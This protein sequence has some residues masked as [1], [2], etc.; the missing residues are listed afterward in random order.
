MALTSVISSKELARVAARAYEGKTV[1]VFLAISTASQSEDSLIS[2]W[3]DDELPASFGYSEYSQ[4]IGVG[5]YDGVTLQYDIA[6][7]FASFTATG[8]SLAWTEIVIYIDDPVLQS[9]TVT[10]T[11][12][13]DGTLHTITKAAGD[14][15]ADGFVAGEY[16]TVSGTSNVNGTYEISSVAALTLTLNST[17]TPLPNSEGPVSSTLTRSLLYPYAVL[18]ENPN[19]S[20]ADGQSHTYQFELN[21]NDA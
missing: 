3:R 14:F 18:T 15:A 17:R 7:F 10:D 8:G 13:Y 16:V 9:E 6:P 5:S 19:M 4:A 12:T 11:F 2:A 20:L 21:T 1:R